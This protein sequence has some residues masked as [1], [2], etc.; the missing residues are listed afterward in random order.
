MLE[1]KLS[2]LQQLLNNTQGASEDGW[3]VG[4]I[5]KKKSRIYLT[6]DI[7]TYFNDDFN[8]M[9]WLCLIHLFRRVTNLSTLTVQSLKA[10]KSSTIFNDLHMITGIL[11]TSKKES[12]YL[13]FLYDHKQKYFVLWYDSQLFLSVNN[14]FP[15]IPFFLV[16]QSLCNYHNDPWPRIK[17]VIYL[18]DS[19]HTHFQTSLICIW[20]FHWIVWSNLISLILNSFW[21]SFL[22]F[23]N[24][25]Y[26]VMTLFG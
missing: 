1:Q 24:R 6:L 14:V 5:W 20:L 7:K 11:D 10:K 25:F 9:T 13:F 22:H 17:V 21:N 2:T 19:N 12:W 23:S 18:G 8:L 3:Q 15:S 26:L 4:V 16:Y